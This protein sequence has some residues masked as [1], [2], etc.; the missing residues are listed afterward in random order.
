MFADDDWKISQKDE[1]S[2][3]SSATSAMGMMIFRGVVGRGCA[4]RG[5]L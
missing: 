5:I 4:V 2:F 3:L 1:F